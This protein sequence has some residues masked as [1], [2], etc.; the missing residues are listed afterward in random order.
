MIW[1]KVTRRYPVRNVLGASAAVAT[2]AL[3][4][5]ACGGGGTGTSSA[6]GSS[7]SGG[8]NCSVKLALFAPYTG[9]SASLGQYQADAV[10]LAL[11]NYTSARLGC[12]VAL[13]KFDTQ[14]TASVTPPLATAA[15]QNSQI[16]AVVG[17]T[18]TG[19][20]EAA[21]PIF[22]SANL[23]MISGVASGITL[24]QH[25]W[26]T[27]HRT[28]ESD[29]V[30]GAGDALYLSKYMKVQSVAL[31]N[32]GQA[33][34][35]GIEQVVQSDLQR[36]G[37]KVPAN[38]SINPTASDYSAQALQIKGANASAVYCGCLAP[39]AARLIK[40]LRNAGVTTPF[41]GPAGI[42]TS[43]FIKTAGAASSGAIATAATPSPEGSAAI[44]KLDQ[45]FKAKFHLPAVAGYFVPQWYDAANAYL[46]AIAAGNHTRAAINRWLSTANFQ[47]VT[48]PIKFDAHGNV[49]GH[50][51]SVFK[52][53]GGSFQF[54]KQIVIP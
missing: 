37:V 15:A 6:G 7:S 26:S 36:D 48:G 50:T 51:E 32:N 19:P 35:Q 49:V 30:D 14:G 23:P 1:T 2:V 12:H 52:V 4:L 38:I 25:G 22:A 33:Y 9:S 29:A 45:Q 24:A 47:G 8:K 53:A 11:D 28:V 39:E 13:Q 18:F 20:T 3:G 10:Q 16:V 44:Q 46:K 43:D 31:V 27:F 41:V 40:A 54:V 34:G 5:S 17:P 21:G 42:E